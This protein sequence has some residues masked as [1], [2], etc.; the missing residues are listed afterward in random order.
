MNLMNNEFRDLSANVVG[1]V[2]EIEGDENVVD[3]EEK[4]L[5]V[6]PAHLSQSEGVA[7]EE[8]KKRNRRLRDRVEY[9]KRRRVRNG[10]EKL[11]QNDH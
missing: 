5:K 1:A 10:G 9:E 11:I 8:K 2:C 3:E 4:E 6:A 7:E